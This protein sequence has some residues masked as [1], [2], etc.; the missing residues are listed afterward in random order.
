MCTRHLR[1][2]CRLPVSLIHWLLVPNPPISC[3]SSLLCLANLPLALWLSTTAFKVCRF[4]AFGF[5]LN[6][7]VHLVPCFSPTTAL[8]LVALNPCLDFLA[9]SRSS[10]NE[11]SAR[12][13]STKLHAPLAHRRVIACAFAAEP[14]NGEASHVDGWHKKV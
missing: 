12:L 9:L 2:S 14:A 8:M 11:L 4:T 13:S 7:L 5:L 1:R 10:S 3:H 6:R